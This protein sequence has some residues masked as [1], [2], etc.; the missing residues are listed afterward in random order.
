VI[1]GA[2]LDLQKMVDDRSNLWGEFNIS[3]HEGTYWL[4]VSRAGYLGTN[5]TVM[6]IAGNT[7]DLGWITLDPVPVDILEDESTRIITLLVSILVVVFLIFLMVSVYIF[8]R[9]QTHGISHDDREQMLE[10]L[11][12]FDVSTRIHE[13]DCYEILGVERKATKKD[14]KK[15]YRKLAAKHHPDR[16]MHK[17]DFDEDEAHDRMK[18]INAAKNILMDDEKRDLHDRILRVTKRY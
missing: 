9:H 15:A 12:H 8:R 14:I 10:I 1:G 6:I 2:K 11:R 17:E 5:I 3:Y 7:T 13:I 4:N 16:M 18:E